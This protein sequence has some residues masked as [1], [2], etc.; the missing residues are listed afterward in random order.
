[1]KRKYNTVYIRFNTSSDNEVLCWRVMC[2]GYEYLT[3]KV[4]IEGEVY[5]TK[6]LLSKIGYRHHIT[7]NDA[8][9]DY[10]VNYTLIRSC[11]KMIFKDIF[12]TITYRILGTSVTFG[13]GFLTTGNISVATT[14]GFSD[15][16]LKPIVYFIHERLWRIRKN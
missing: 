1:M 5:T 11:K 4:K 13:I 3:D 6:N 8:I 12:K 15:L 10:S 2:D 7:I 14:L 16:I 9:V